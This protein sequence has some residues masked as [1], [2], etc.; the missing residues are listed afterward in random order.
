MLEHICVYMYMYIHVHVHYSAWL[1]V[2]IWTVGIGACTVHVHVIKLHVHMYIVSVCGSA[3]C[4]CMVNGSVAVAALWVFSMYTQCIG[5]ASPSH[6]PQAAAWRQVRFS[7]STSSIRRLP[8][9]SMNTTNA[10]IY[11]L[12]FSKVWGWMCLYTG[13]RLAIK[14]IINHNMYISVKPEY[15]P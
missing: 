1:V 5:G 14:D 2:E 3:H 9:E 10:N 11:A 15:N 7:L 8:A 12:Y 4:E 13:K 6:P